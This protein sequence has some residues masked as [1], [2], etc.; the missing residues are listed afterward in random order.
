[1]FC[2]MTVHSEK[3]LPGYIPMMFLMLVIIISVG[4]VAGLTTELKEVGVNGKWLYLKGYWI[5]TST[6][7]ANIVAIEQ[8]RSGRH[9]WISTRIAVRLR[10]PT[11][12]GY[13]IYFESTPEYWLFPFGRSEPLI[14]EF[15]ALARAA[16]A[17]LL[18]EEHLS[19]APDVSKFRQRKA[20]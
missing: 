2:Y 7:L 5:E 17:I 12:F 8:V 6:P 18:G 13:T 3:S 4:A 19:T 20:K 11:A 1:V 10:D 14:D 9:S 16:G 15:K